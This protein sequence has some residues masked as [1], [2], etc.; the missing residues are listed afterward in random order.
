[1]ESVKG[2]DELAELRTFAIARSGAL[3]GFRLK[4]HNDFTSNDDGVTTG[5][6]QDVLIG[7]GNGSQTQ[8]QLVK[9][10]TSGLV[11]I[12]RNIRKPVAATVKIWVNG[13]LKTEGVDYTVD[14]TTG[15][16][17]MAVAPT[18]GH[19]VEA[20]FEFDVPVR[21][22][23]EVDRRFLVR[24]DD[25][26]EGSIS[27]LPCMEIVDPEPPYTDFFYGGATT[28]AV[29][30]DFTLSTSARTWILSA[31]TAGKKAILPDP[32]DIPDGGPIF[33]LHNAGANNILV[34]DHNGST[35]L[36]LGAGQGCNVVLFTDGA[37]A[38]VWAAY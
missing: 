35:L 36:T 19:A 16:V 2:L 9:K 5:S 18:A 32:T 33:R 34:V 26:E 8:F 21:F 1:V 28:K 24:R 15:V 27:S 29:T 4:D 14:T 30:A 20:S 6:D 25:V 11:T 31:G 38:K 12:T 37:S 10:Y 13:V 3:H 17:T 23:S 22:D 7:T